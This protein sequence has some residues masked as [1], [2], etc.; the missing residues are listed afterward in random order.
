MR[1]SV[2]GTDRAEQ[3]GSG[4]TE[5]PPRIRHALTIQVGYVLLDFQ[6]VLC[7]AGHPVALKG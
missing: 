6:M 4:K 2:K 5:A 7:K 1:P 3:Q